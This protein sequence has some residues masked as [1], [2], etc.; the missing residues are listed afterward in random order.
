MTRF[1]IGVLFVMFYAYGLGLYHGW[2]Y[3]LHA[4]AAKDK[5]A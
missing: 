1:D 5:G 2:G 3:C 4:Q